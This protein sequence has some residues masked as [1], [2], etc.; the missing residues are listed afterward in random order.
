MVHGW[1]LPPYP[2]YNIASPIYHGEKVAEPCEMTPTLIMILTDWILL[3][4]LDQQLRAPHWMQLLSPV[5]PPC[6]KR[7]LPIYRP[8][9]VPKQGISI[10]HRK[11]MLSVSPS[12]FFY[13]LVFTRLRGICGCE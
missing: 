7:L 10:S 6:Q 12:H 4:L 2:L 3:V 9:N 11:K 5:R 8:T 13:L 1:G